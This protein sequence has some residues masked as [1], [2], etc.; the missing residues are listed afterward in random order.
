MT[1]HPH[2]SMS[3][4]VLGGEGLRPESTPLWHTLLAR[5]PDKERRVLV[6]QAT[7]DDHPAGTRERR[8]K[9]ITESLE[10]L[11]LIIEVV[12]LKA[13][14]PNPSAA[15]PAS[16]VYLTGDTRS[17]CSCL[18]G[19]TLWESICSREHRPSLLIASGGAS[20]ALGERAFAPRK[21]YPASLDALEFDTLPGLALLPNLMILPYYIWLPDEVIY[22]IAAMVSDET[23]L[24]GIDDQAALITSDH[25]WKVDGLGSVTVFR[26]GV[27]PRMIDAG[28]TV[29]A[30]LLSPIR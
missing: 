7:T 12:S 13:G 9:L 19:T 2:S 3:V 27:A 24:V 1:E 20:V 29:P 22:K 10:R 5:L 16:A 18:V 23:I 17:L 26:R 14:A 15:A 11:G 28:I 8:A 30:D 21:P 4:A 25:T 6:V